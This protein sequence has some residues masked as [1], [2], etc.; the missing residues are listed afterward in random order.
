MHVIQ[1]LFHSL[2]PD[3][4]V[5]KMAKKPNAN[6]NITFQ[7][8]VFLSLQKSF[9]ETG[10]SAESNDSILSNHLREKHLVQVIFDEMAVE[11]LICHQFLRE[12][13]NGHLIL[14]IV[15]EDPDIHFV[16]QAF[17]FQKLWFLNQSS[18]AVKPLH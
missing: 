6:D 3:L 4:I 16:A 15:T 14:Q 12:V 1:H 8:Q 11:T 10:T 9:L 2:I 5:A 17:S 18:E 13:P 7:S